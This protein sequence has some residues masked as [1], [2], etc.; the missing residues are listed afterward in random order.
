MMQRSLC[1]LIIL[2]CL[3]LESRMPSVALAPGAEQVR[4]TKNPADVAS[5]KAAGSILCPST[6][7]RAR[8]PLRT[9]SA[10]FAIRSLAWGATRHW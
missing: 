1:V 7:I 8:C 3:S 5:C 10:N 9:P 2:A 4:L 6:P